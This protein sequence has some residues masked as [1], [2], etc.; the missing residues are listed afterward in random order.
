MYKGNYKEDLR[1]GYGEMHWTDG[2][3]YKGEWLKGIQHGYGEMIFPDGKRKSGIF[4]NNTYVGKAERKGDSKDRNSRSR[5][6][7]LSSNGRS[8]ERSFD[9]RV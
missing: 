8:Q 9:K 7:G 6:K 2:S 1:H 4:E 3:I 5:S